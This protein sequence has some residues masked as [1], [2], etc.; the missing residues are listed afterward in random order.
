MEKDG[1]RAGKHLVQHT[2]R[3][4]VGMMH[5]GTNLAQEF[6]SLGARLVARG[7]GLVYDWYRYIGK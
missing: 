7:V 5:E 1:C 4:G 3:A 2:C 6:C